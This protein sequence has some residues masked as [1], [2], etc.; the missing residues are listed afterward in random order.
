MFKTVEMETVNLKKYVE[1]SSERLLKAVEGEGILGDRK[2][3]W[4]R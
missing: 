2:K 4:I 1:N 3:S